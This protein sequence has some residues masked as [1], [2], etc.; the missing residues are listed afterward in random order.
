MY[1]RKQYNKKLYNRQSLIFKIILKSNGPSLD[2][3]MKKGNG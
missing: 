3:G 1:Q 2:K